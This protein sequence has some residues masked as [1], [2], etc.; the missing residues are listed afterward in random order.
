MARVKPIHTLL[1]G[2][3][4]HGDLGGLTSY[5]SRAGTT[6]WFTKSPPL[7][8]PSYHQRIMRNRFR[9]VA[10]IW[11]SMEPSKKAA[12]KRAT[13]KASLRITAYAL[14]LW[15]HTHRDRATIATIERQT[16]E[17]LL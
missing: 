3:R 16:G 1:L 12:W 5:T 11:K 4:P 6:V 7:T 17:V 14:F 15:Y 13:E 10:L 9:Q 2:W 8:P